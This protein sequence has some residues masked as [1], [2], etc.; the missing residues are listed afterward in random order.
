MYSTFK[1]QCNVKLFNA[2]TSLEAN[3]FDGVDECSRLLIYAGK[4]WVFLYSPSPSGFLMK[5]QG[6]G[7]PVSRLARLQ[8][9]KLV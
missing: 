4:S 7:I 6:M 5:L 9:F 3:P 2:Q 8:C 1:I